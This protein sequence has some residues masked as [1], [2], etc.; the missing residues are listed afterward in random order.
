M[1]DSFF[2]IRKQKNVQDQCSLCICQ[3]KI[4]AKELEE[5]QTHYMLNWIPVT[6]GLAKSG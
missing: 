3:R 4:E 6:I 5:F 2:A 1:R